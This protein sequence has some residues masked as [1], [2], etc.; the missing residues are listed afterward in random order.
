LA[1][2]PSARHDWRAG[3]P[4]LIVAREVEEAYQ[5]KD[6]RRAIRDRFVWTLQLDPR[7]EVIAYAIAH[8][9]T[10][11]AP[12]DRSRMLVEGFDVTW[13]QRQ[14]TSWWD[15]GFQNARTVDAFRA[16][17]EEMVGLGVLRAV[18]TTRYA[19]RSPNVVALLGT[20]EEIEAKLLEPRLAEPSYDASTMR[21][22]LEVMPD[23]RRSPLTWQQESL[24]VSKG[25]VFVLCAS[26]AAGLSDCSKRLEQLMPKHIRSLGAGSSRYELTRAL[27]RSHRGEPRVALVSSEALWD[28][29]WLETAFA[30]LSRKEDRDDSKA[31]FLCDPSRLWA[32][33]QRGGESLD[34]YVTRL[35]GYVLTLGPWGDVMVQAWLDDCGLAA[36]VE[37]LKRIRN[38][39]GNWPVLLY[40]FRAA[41]GDHAARWEESLAELDA[42]LEAEQALQD[43]LRRSFGLTPGLPAAVIHWVSMQQEIAEEDIVD[44]LEGTYHP[45]A[46]RH[47]LEWGRL[48]NL[49]SFG[50]RG[51]LRLDPVVR[52]LARNLPG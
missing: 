22:P 32:L 17:L 50:A 39:T 29:D 34:A 46:V 7:Y 43:Q 27:R 52:R 24:L 14:A 47:A 3:P 28:K 16:L 23:S 38:T 18:G 37:H 5:S 33:L 10:S 8:E 13:L 2:Q 15:D 35:G 44:L 1:T 41:A 20:N 21:A 51:A 25:G 45:D 31:I 30:A 36:Q 19:L 49:I 42:S 6:L 11:S 12:E 48:L 9:I 26:E 40:R 4:F